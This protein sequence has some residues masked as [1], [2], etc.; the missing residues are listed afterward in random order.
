MYLDLK[1]LAVVMEKILTWICVVYTF[2]FTL[3]NIENVKRV[4]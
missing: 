2:D 1:S 4:F 3:I